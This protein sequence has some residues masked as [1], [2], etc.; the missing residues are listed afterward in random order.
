MGMLKNPRHEAFAQAISRGL[1]ATEAYKHVG[2]QGDRHHAARLATSGHVVERVTE[3]KARHVATASVT[4][5]WVLEQLVELTRKCMQKEPILDPDGKP[6]IGPLQAGPANK[7]LELIG[8]ELGMFID[9][10]EIG[11]PGD[12]DRLDDAELGTLLVAELAARRL[13]S[14]AHARRGA[15]AEAGEG[16]PN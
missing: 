4:K 3:L 7:A 16:Q 10:A 13:A 5:A 12:F 1:S 6:V 11:R 2:Y 15:E 9:R 8:K 14:G